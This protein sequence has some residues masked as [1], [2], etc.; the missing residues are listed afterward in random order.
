M[1]S[2]HPKQM[3]VLSYGNF[4]IEQDFKI[5]ILQMFQ[6]LEDPKPS[7]VKL[8]WP[9]LGKTLLWFFILSSASCYSSVGL[10]SRDEILPDLGKESLALQNSMS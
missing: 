10:G 7:T 2:T 4:K 1:V 9:W 3:W 5:F 6:N 8:S